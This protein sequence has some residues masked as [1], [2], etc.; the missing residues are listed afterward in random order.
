MSAT[1]QAP[2]PG[3]YIGGGK[4]A[5]IDN[6]SLI[7]AVLWEEA[8][9]KLRAITKASGQSYYDRSP[10]FRKV[11][12]VVEEFIKDFENHGYQE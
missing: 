3:T 8:K 7:K 6:I 2:A 9:G 10:D 5:A 12:E 11:K 4:M 1:C